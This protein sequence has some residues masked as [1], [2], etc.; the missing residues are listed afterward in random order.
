MSILVNRAGLVEEN[1]VEIIHHCGVHL[2]S[3]FLIKIS[4][5]FRKNNNVAVFLFSSIS[6]CFGHFWILRIHSRIISHPKDKKFL[7]SL[8]ALPLSDNP[9]FI[10]SPSSIAAYGVEELLRDF[11]FN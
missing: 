6:S 4:S 2:S 9:G 3:P 5:P 7:W 8:P 11:P 1:V 10:R